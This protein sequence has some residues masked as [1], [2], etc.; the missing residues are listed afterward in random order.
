MTRSATVDLAVFAVKSTFV[1]GVATGLLGMVNTVTETFCAIPGASS[2]IAPKL[3]AFSTTL[4][5][6]G[7][8][9][10]HSTVDNNPLFRPDTAQL[11]TQSAQWVETHLLAANYP[12][13]FVLAKSTV[14]LQELGAI[15]R[16]NSRLHSRESMATQ[17]DTFALHTQDVGRELSRLRV[18]ALGAVGRLG[19]YISHLLQTLEGERSNRFADPLL[20]LQRAHDYAITQIDRELGT[21]HT[22]CEAVLESLRVA[23]QHLLTIT[24]SVQS[25]W[26]LQSADAD[27]MRRADGAL[28]A[29]W[30]WLGSNVVEKEKLD[31]NF[32]LLGKLQQEVSGASLDVKSTMH[33]LEMFQ[34]QLAQLKVT[35]GVSAY[36]DLSLETHIMAVQ[37]SLKRLQGS[38]KKLAGKMRELEG[39]AI[40]I[41]A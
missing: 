31:A 14:A 9:H 27:D 12:A 16:Y 39:E 23:D 1:L 2:L 11:A 18:G 7:S 19:V 36:G 33:G 5:N 6:Y 35:A 17:I 38:E 21:L 3:C 24:A 40:G 37:D 34:E 41:E 10:S 32:K 13:T 20:A 25:E 29:L 22:R 26:S 28:S 15:V 4:N 8:H 30:S